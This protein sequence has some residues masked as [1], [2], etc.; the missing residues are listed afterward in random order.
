MACR[1]PMSMTPWGGTFY[2]SHD[3]C[4]VAQT[5][6][7]ATRDLATSSQRFTRAETCCIMARHGNGFVQQEGTCCWAMRG[8]P[9]GRSRI[10]G[11]RKRRRGLRRAASKRRHASRAHRNILKTLEKQKT[12]REE[13]LH[14]CGG[15]R[16][17]GSRGGARGRRARGMRRGCAES[18][19]AVLPWRCPPT[20]V[21]RCG[22]STRWWSKGMHCRGGDTTGEGNTRTRTAMSRT[23]TSLQ[24]AHHNS[25]CKVSLE[26]G[27]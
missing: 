14:G 6:V 16:H 9:K 1:S 5:A 22:R 21:Q 11:C 17:R 18:Q 27:A 13:R 10:R 15:S 12:R 8:S 20:C 7:W 24:S 4:L 3:H 19:H 2:G 23:Q 25:I 26:T